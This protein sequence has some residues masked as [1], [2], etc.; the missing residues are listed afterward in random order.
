MKRRSVLAGLSVG[1]AVLAWPALISRAFAQED[2]A[3][4][5]DAFS[6]LQQAWRDAQ[7]NHR[8]LLVLVIPSE[9]LA[10]WDRGRAF[11]AVIN[12]GSDEA[13]AAIGVSELACAR[14]REVRRLFPNAPA[15]EP[16]MLVIRGEASSAMQVLDAPWPEEVGHF[17]GGWREQADTRL[18]SQ[19][20][21]VTQL[22]QTGL[23]AAVQALSP[24]ARLAARE[25]TIAT[26]RA[27]RVPGSHWA[28]TAGCGT[29]IEEAPVTG[30]I[31]CGMGHVP[32]QAQRFLFFFAVEHNPT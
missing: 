10:A 26:Y 1:S 27:H 4:P 15:G 19:M 32:E 2:D 21:I 20:A 9:P 13:L 16:L 7:A 30:G 23:G 12:H 25:R 8:P 31:G 28:N 5:A 17:R 29:T 24:A 22:L 3:T 14:M 18:V 6:S 11:G